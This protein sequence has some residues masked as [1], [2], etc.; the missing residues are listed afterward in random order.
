VGNRRFREACG[1]DVPEV[2]A[3]ERVDRNRDQRLV[4]A[5]IGQQRAV[6]D[7]LTVR[8][9]SGAAMTAGSVSPSATTVTAIA[10]V[11]NFN[12]FSRI[13]CRVR[14]GVA[15]ASRVIDGGDAAPMAG[16]AGY[17]RCAFSPAC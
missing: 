9:E 4:L 5:A 15:A 2:Q 12:A 7:G 10:M 11:R 6:A 14:A 1:L 3:V 8:D 13:R 17:P 16:G